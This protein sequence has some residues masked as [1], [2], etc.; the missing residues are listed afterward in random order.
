MFGSKGPVI[1]RGSAL[2]RAFGSLAL[3]VAVSAVPLATTS[4]AVRTASGGFGSTSITCSMSLGW[5]R[6][7]VTLR[8]ATGLSTQTV[9]FRRYIQPL[10]GSG[11]WTTWTTRTAPFSTT[12][13][14]YMTNASFKIYVEY[15][16]YR[17]GSWTIAGEWITSYGQAYGTA[18]Y[19]WSYCAV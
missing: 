8:P 18:V 12:Y 6:E 16:W 13:V 1:G 9:A 19:S 10:G 11:F 3:A 5:V 14:T 17:N 7:S 2:R 4:A 15:A